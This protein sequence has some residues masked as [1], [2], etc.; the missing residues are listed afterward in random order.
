MT[1][2][3]AKMMAELLFFLALTT[4][5]TTLGRLGKSSLTNKN[6]WLDTWQRKMK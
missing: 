4:K 3:V 6:S 2:F 5:V 1:E